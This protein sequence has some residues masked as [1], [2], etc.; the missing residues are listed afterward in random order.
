MCDRPK[1]DQFALPTHLSHQ[2]LE[3]QHAQSPPVHRSRVR[4]VRQHFGR[5]ELGRTA[6]RA[7]PIVEAHALLTQPEIGNLHVTLRVQQQIVQ[8]QIAI[9]DLALVQIL[10]AQHHAGRIEHGAR[11]RKDVGMDVHHEITAGRVLHH[12]A[13]VLLGL[14]A[15]KQIHEE[16]MAHRVGHL[17]NALL[18]Q[19]RFDLV[20]RNDVA[21]L[22]RLDGK[23]FA[24]G[25]ERFVMNETRWHNETRLD[26]RYR[27]N[28]YFC[29]VTE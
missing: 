22:Q 10:Q 15:R 1:P 17:E 4:R 19:Q 18:A 26:S 29:T 25:R 6:E 20:A 11:L 7:R 27:T 9:D 12:E 28:R 21:L 24:C 8:L 23:V 3:N 16:R 2:H 14:E 5:Q 13:H